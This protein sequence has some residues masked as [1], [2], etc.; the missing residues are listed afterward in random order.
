MT[1]CNIRVIKK[2]IA[3][4]QEKNVF[5][6]SAYTFKISVCENR[7]FSRFHGDDDFLLCISFLSEEIYYV[8]KQKLVI[9]AYHHC[10]VN[11]AHPS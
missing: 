9:T 8:C 4:Y 2:E 6:P 3:L 11:L 5:F 1:W 10:V 7:Y